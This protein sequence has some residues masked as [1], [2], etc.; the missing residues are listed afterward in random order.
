MQRKAML[1]ATKKHRFPLLCQKAS[2]WPDVPV[3][4]GRDGLAVTLTPHV[5]S[6][7]LTKKRA[8]KDGEET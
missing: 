4:E 6:V 1:L 7:T 5:Q 2:N 3:V 8:T